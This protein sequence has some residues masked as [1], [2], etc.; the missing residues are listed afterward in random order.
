MNPTAEQRKILNAR[1]RVVKINARAGTGKTA[2]LLMLAQANLDKKILYLVF[3][4]RNRLEA[5]AKFPPNV[6]IHTV[7]SFA[8]STSDGK[9]DGFESIR[10]SHFSSTSE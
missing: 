5:K 2:T 9:F 6:Y 7:H 4:S 8:L 3:N 10:P 1:G